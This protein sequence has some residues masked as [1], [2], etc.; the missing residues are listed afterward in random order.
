MALPQQNYPSISSSGGFS[1]GPRIGVRV[2]AEKERFFDREAVLRRLGPARVAVYN[3][4]GARVRQNAQRSMKR[5]RRKRRSE[6][7]KK[8]RQHYE[9]V[10]RQTF[11]RN[12]KFGLP[13]VHSEPGAPPKVLGGELKKHIYYAADYQL[14][15]AV[16]GPIRFGTILNVPQILEYGGRSVS[17][18]YG[19]AVFIQERP[20]MRPALEY[21][22]QGSPSFPELWKDAIHK[23]Y[24]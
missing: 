14:E 17:R 16:I 13:F 5:A 3:R 19:R 9:I 4:M 15:T 12:P 21:A 6:L 10:Q 23:H 2:V 8:E 20:Y 18:R 1:F 24:S 22:L 11:G 7:T